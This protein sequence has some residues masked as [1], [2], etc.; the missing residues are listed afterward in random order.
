[1]T[2]CRCEVPGV[3]LRLAHSRISKGGLKY[4]SE[5]EGVGDKTD[6]GCK[7]GRGALGRPFKDGQNLC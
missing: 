7:V 1:M 6:E 4:K 5:D 3:E 2:M